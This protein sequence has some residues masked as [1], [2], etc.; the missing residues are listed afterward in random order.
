MAWSST[1]CSDRSRFWVPC[2]SSARSG[3]SGGWGSVP[4]SIAAPTVPQVAATASPM[5]RL[6][7]Y[8]SPTHK[9][10]TGAPADSLQNLVDRVGTLQEAAE[11]NDFGRELL[12]ALDGASPE[13]AFEA[14]ARVPG[15]PR[16]GHDDRELRG[17]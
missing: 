12:T 11:A 17:G 4:S 13:V 2:S 10:S 8:P 14:V 1:S 5:S 3:R 15:L 9:G 16:R 6:S 7:H